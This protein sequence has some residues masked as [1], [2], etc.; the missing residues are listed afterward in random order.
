LRSTSRRY[1]DDATTVVASC[2]RFQ[3]KDQPQHVQAGNAPEVDD[4]AVPD[5]EDVEPPSFTA[6]APLLLVCAVP[7]VDDVPVVEGVG[8]S[9]DEQPAVV[10]PIPSTT[11]V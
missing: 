4:D 6:S 9:D 1:R 7:E 11:I 2:S 3:P 5:D 10:I 8:S